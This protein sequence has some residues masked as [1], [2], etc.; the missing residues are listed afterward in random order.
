MADFDP[1]DFNTLAQLAHLEQRG[2]IRDQL[3]AQLEEA[4]AQHKEAVNRER[5]RQQRPQCPVCG[6][7]LEGQFRKCMHCQ[8]NLEW[9]E[10]IP[11]EPM[12]AE[13]A[14]QRLAI[15]KN[16]E[17][18]A[19]IAWEAGADERAKLAREQADESERFRREQKERNAVFE[20]AMSESR[21]FSFAVFVLGATTSALLLTW[22]FPF[23]V[24]GQD[25]FHNNIVP[26]PVLS[27]PFGFI[28][29]RC[30]ASLT[31]QWF[32]ARAHKVVA[33]WEQ[34]RRLL[35]SHRESLRNSEIKAPRKR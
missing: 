10:G 7:R 9:V 34:I 17:K 21:P 22:Y 12:D 1:T 29:G 24:L 31:T 19:R 4:R 5:E 8:S 20:R 32:K 33:K 2:Q 6:G 30:L 11:Y 25:A 27:L 35:D 18:E 14:R 3:R 26:S 15:A 13:I 28:T 23:S 16:K